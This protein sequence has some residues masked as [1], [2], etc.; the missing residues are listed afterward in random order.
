M[1]K[2]EWL[3]LAG[4][5]F[6]LATAGTVPDV[7]QISHW[8]LSFVDSL[9]ADGFLRSYELPPPANGEH[10]FRPL[11]VLLLKIYLF[12]CSADQLVPMAVVFVKVFACAL[13]LGHASFC[14]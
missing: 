3:W 5:S 4:V 11:S 10:G 2:R 6:L 14:G 13:I 9:P 8:V 7:D 12:M 1:N